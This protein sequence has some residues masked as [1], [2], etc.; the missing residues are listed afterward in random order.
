MGWVTQGSLKFVPR[1]FF[2]LTAKCQKMTGADGRTVL[3][4][5]EISVEPAA[6]PKEKYISFT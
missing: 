6:R 3:M 2:R 5:H 1:H 4:L